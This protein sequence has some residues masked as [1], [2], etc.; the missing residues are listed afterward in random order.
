M[1]A[2]IPWE[3]PKVTRIGRP[4]LVL[5]PMRKYDSVEF[6]RDGQTPDALFKQFCLDTFGAISIIS[7]HVKG[8]WKNDR[9]CLISDTHQE[10]RV[11]F[12]RSG[13]NGEDYLDI[14][15]NFLSQLAGLMQEECIYAE[16][17]EES[18]LISA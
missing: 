10:Y 8:D 1:A 3:H 2:K 16:L 5:L 7:S 4:A 18:V 12:L 14:F 17:G 13:F 11:S 15:I 6:G 9:Q